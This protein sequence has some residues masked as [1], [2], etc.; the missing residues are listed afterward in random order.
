MDY[1]IIE[2][3]NAWLDKSNKHMFPD[4]DT[5]CRII[6]LAEEVGEVSGA[7]I[8]MTGQNPRKGTTHTLDDVLDELADVAVTAICAIQ[9]FTKNRNRTEYIV[10][11]KMA[12]LEQRVVDA[13]KAEIGNRVDL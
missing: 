2:A 5:A 13:A 4:V 9:H 6:K 8:G 12:L 11:T 10:S 3:A 7:Y 1:R